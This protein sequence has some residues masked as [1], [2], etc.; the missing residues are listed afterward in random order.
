MRIVFLFDP[1]MVRLP[2]DVANL[3]T[4]DRGLTGSEVTFFRL[5]RE[6]A[7]RKHEVIL[8]SKVVDAVSW[9]DVRCF[10]WEFWMGS[11]K[12]PRVHLPWD[13]AISYISADP[14]A[15]ET[16]PRTAFRIVHQQCRGWSMSAPGWEQH[17]D[18][19]CP[20][21][22]VHARDLRSYPLSIADLVL[23]PFR[24][25]PNGVDMDEF[26]P[27]AKIPG[28]VIWASSPERGLHRLLE[29]WP[30]VR[31]AVPTA[32]LDVFYDMHSLDNT[33]DPEN[34]ARAR[35]IK[36]ALPKLARQGVMVRGST[37]RKGI[38]SA[39]AQAEILA[40]PLESRELVETFGCTVLEAMAAGCVP[41]LCFDDAFEEL[42]GEAALGVALPIGQ[43]LPQYAATV[44]GLLKDDV[45]RGAVAARCREHAA[46]YAWSVL[47][48]KLERCI[49]TRGAEG[50]DAPAW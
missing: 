1:K 43:H 36:A 14:L 27:G 2:F 30:L 47:A 28:R 18:L 40:Y 45:W 20:L 50:L 21:S 19:V 48:D 38:A 46:R 10:P 24:L 15:V 44:V 3:W 33:P 23:P 22:S 8:Y 26:K 34:Q 5:A 4:S 11:E 41:A 16:L 17:V 7:K 6:M 12:I 39:M 9:G 29:V 37:S 35:Y 49:L 31:K 25:L 13:A 32:T 42:W